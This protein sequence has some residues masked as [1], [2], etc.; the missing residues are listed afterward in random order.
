[1]IGDHYGPTAGRA[2]VL[3][4]AVDAILGTHK[5]RATILAV[6]DCRNLRVAAD[7]LRAGKG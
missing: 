4:R 6:E 2:T 1:M 3:V 7:T 5:V